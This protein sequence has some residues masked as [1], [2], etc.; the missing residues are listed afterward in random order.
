MMN[1]WLTV[2]EEGNKMFLY[3]MD[4]IR[5]QPDKVQSR[6]RINLNDQNFLTVLEVVQLSCICVVAGNEVSFYN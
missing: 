5:T 3:D 1:K 2:T 6:L 4:R